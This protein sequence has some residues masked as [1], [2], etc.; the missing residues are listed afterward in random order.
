MAA[1][2]GG[3]GWTSS[4]T[5]G[6]TSNEAEM[7]MV[8]QMMTNLQ[9]A[10]KQTLRPMDERA[11]DDFPDSPED[12]MMSPV[13]PNTVLKEGKYAKNK[14]FWTVERTYLQDKSYVR[15]VRAHIN[16]D[17][18]LEMQRLRVYVH[19]RDNRKKIRM[20]EH[21]YRM[22]IQM[23]FSPTPGIMMNMGP[24]CTPA[25]KLPGMKEARNVPKS[26]KT[27]GAPRGSEEM[28]VDHW[29]MISEAESAQKHEKAMQAWCQMV[30]Q[31]NRNQI[32]REKEMSMHLNQMNP[33]MLSKFVMNM[34]YM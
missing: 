33:A 4:P 32:I 2:F 11:L 1:Y 6:S 34:T 31:M 15:W 9:Q 7:Y 19:Y 27:R 22:E 18:C 17:S 16:Q 29:S 25:T 26:L 10:Q 5:P 30:G 14:L 3:G 8:N 28:E 12:G 24:P 21:K 13:P 23:P 20:D